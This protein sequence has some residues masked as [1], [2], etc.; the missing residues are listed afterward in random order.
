VLVRALLA[1]AANAQHRC[2]SLNAEEQNPAALG[3]ADAARPPD[4][5]IS[6]RSR[7]MERL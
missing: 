5:P 3:F 1:Q 6:P 2:V 7:W 4:E